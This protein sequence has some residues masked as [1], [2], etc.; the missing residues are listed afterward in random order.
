LSKQLFPVPKLGHWYLWTLSRYFLSFFYD[1]FLWILAFHFCKI[2]LKT[3]ISVNFKVECG[4]CQCF[5]LFRYVKGNCRKIISKCVEKYPNN[6]CYI[7]G[8]MK[9]SAIDLTHLAP[10]AGDVCIPLPFVSSPATCKLFNVDTLHLAI[11]RCPTK[12]KL[13]NTDALCIRCLYIFI[14]FPGNLLNMLLW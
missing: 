5:D 9:D 8:M 7:T 1:F 2:L 11:T 4:M 14:A 3:Y 12:C 10:T 6:F 13:F